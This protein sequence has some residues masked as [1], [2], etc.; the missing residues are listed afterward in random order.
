[1]QAWTID[2]KRYFVF[3]TP[4]EYIFFVPGCLR[5][6]GESGAQNTTGA[7]SGWVLTQKPLEIR[8]YLR[9]VRGS[10][11]QSVTVRDGGTVMTQKILKYSAYLRQASGP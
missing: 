4:K 9:L 6:V 10:V 7:N 2:I 3:T 8:A 11:A 1:M 5:Q